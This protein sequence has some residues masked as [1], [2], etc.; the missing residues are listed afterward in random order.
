MAKVNILDE[1]IIRPMLSTDIE[2]VAKLDELC[3]ALPWGAKAY[4]TELSLP[5]HHWLIATDSSGN[6]LGFAGLMVIPFPPYEAEILN[7]AVDH[8]FRN[9]GIAHRLLSE[10]VVKASNLPQTPVSSIF[11]EVRASNTPAQKAYEKL[12][13]VFDGVRK[14]YYLDNKEDAWLMHLS[15][16]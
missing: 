14:N 4:L 9:Q 2:A 15:L 13:F 7:V 8:G 10:L 16:T 11:L 5:E 12:G 6:L 1:L 3:F